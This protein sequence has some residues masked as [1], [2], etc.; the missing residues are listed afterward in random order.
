MHRMPGEGPDQLVV[1]LA[2]LPPRPLPFEGQTRGERNIRK[3]KSLA[4]RSETSFPKILSTKN[5]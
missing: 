2:A 4:F 5:S 1:A 3:Q